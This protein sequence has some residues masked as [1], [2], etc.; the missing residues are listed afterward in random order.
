MSCEKSGLHAAL[1]TLTKGL[2][3]RTLHPHYH[4][5]K[6]CRG[7]QDRAEGV[8]TSV[9]SRLACLG[10]EPICR[11]R[12]P[13]VALSWLQSTITKIDMGLS[14]RPTKRRKVDTSDDDP[15]LYKEQVVCHEMVEKRLPFA[16]ADV[17]Y[18]AD[19][20]QAEQASQWYE[21]LLKLDTCEALYT[22][23][24]LGC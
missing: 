19:F 16:D 23:R 7:R 12:G 15:D 17:M 1:V 18:C 10:R 6:P 14:S 22:F 5:V 8:N 9:M 2:A 24:R 21:A 20:V 13:F 3:M 4:C 11:S